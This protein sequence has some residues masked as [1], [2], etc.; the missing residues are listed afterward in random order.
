[1]DTITAIATKLDIR[2][3]SARDVP[4]ET[5][6]Q[7]LEAARLT[8]SSMNTQHWRF[9]LV[10]DPANL[11]K[12]AAD[13]TTG[14][15]VEKANFAIVILINPKIPGSAVDGGRV[16]QDMQ[17]AAWDLGVASRLYTGFKEGEMRRDFGIPADLKIEA[18][19]G[20]GYP[21][22]RIIGKKNRKPLD[23][24]AFSE[25]YGRPLSFK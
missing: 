16:L 24:L 12:L 1:M 4:N 2:E 21:A 14:E 20:F 13:G 5:K 7:I 19:L 23:E 6:R 8:G 25:S 18:V 15:W 11:R 9:I 17:L 3:Y 10:Q 22:K